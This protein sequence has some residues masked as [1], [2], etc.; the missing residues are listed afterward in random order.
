VLATGL[1]APSTC[2]SAASSSGDAVAWKAHGDKHR[3]LGG[4]IQIIGKPEHD[5]DKLVGL[6]QAG[7]DGIQVAFFDFAPDLRFFGEAV[8]PL[9]HQAGLRVLTATRRLASDVQGSASKERVSPV[10]ISRR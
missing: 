9:T 1:P 7:C 6:K 5:V 2:A 3:T 8:L 10:G 4:N